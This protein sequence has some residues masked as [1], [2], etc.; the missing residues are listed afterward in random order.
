MDEHNEGLEPETEPTGPTGQPEIDFP[1]HESTSY[2]SSTDFTPI[3]STLN[4]NHQAQMELLQKLHT[5][6]NQIHWTLIFFIGL[7]AG[8]AFA[9]MFLRGWLSSNR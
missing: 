6:T 1:H 4:D 2:E 8:I 7:V 5:D 3:V 9:I